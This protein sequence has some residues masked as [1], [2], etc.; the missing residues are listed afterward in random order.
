MFDWEKIGSHHR[1][2]QVVIDV[3]SL[4]HETAEGFDSFL[5]L[6]FIVFCLF[7]PIFSSYSKTQYTPTAQKGRQSVRKFMPNCVISFVLL[8]PIA[9][10]WEF[11][12]SRIQLLSS[13]I[14]TFSP[15]QIRLCFFVPLEFDFASH[16]PPNSKFERE[17]IVRIPE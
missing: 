4:V 9:Y 11:F 15:T 13:H 5:S 16:S 17:R 3:D 14:F 10:W 6:F 2:G 1:M 12:G 7:L 8:F